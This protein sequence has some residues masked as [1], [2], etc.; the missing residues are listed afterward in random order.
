MSKRRPITFWA[1]ADDATA[2]LPGKKDAASELARL[3]RKAD[4]VRECLRAVQDLAER[5][6]ERLDVLVDEIARL[7]ERIVAA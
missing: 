4:D 5:Q 3:S 1:E 6:R 7:G 2:P